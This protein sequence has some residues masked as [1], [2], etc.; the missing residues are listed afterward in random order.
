MHLGDRRLDISY[1]GKVV[2]QANAA[3]SGQALVVH[4]LC[5]RHPADRH[6]YLPKLGASEDCLRGDRGALSRSDTC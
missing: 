2:H 4:H 1:A 5:T 6:G 3:R